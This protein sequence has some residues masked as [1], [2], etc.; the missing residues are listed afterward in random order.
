MLITNRSG[1]PVQRSP[2]GRCW[3]AAIAGAGLPRGTRFHDLRHFYASS[4]IRANLNPKVIQTRLGHATIAATMDTYG[5]LFPDDEDL[6]RG[7]VEAM[8]AA[9]LAEQQHHV[10]A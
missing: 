10:A 9:T 4:L 5:H 3:R 2:F 6:G 7:A 1:R 8:I